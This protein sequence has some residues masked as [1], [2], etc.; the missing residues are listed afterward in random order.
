MRLTLEFLNH[1][2]KIDYETIEQKSLSPFYR[3]D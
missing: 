3:Y 2:K 1:V